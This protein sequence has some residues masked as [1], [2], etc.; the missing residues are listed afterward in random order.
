MGKDYWAEEM[1]AS[2]KD[3]DYWAEEMGGGEKTPKTNIAVGV[4]KGMLDVVRGAT[5]PLVETSA[6]TLQGIEGLAKQ[7]MG[8]EPTMRTYNVP[9]YGEI[10][11][12]QN[13]K[14]AAGNALQTSATILPT[15]KPALAGAM[16]SGG[17]SLSRNED[18]ISTAFNT[19]LGAIT[20][21]VSSSVMGLDKAKLIQQAGNIYRKVLRPTASEIKKIDIGKGGDINTYFQLAAKEKL[22]I[23]MTEGKLNTTEAISALQAKQSNLHEQLNN[24]LSKDT[25]KRFNLNNIRQ[26]AKLNAS[27]SIKNASELKV[28]KNNIDSL[29]DA[30]IERLGGEKI[31][32]AQ[33]L[34]NI[35]QGMWSVSYNP[36]D[37][38]QNVKADS[39]RKIGYI[40]KTMIEDFAPSSAIQ[41]LN[42]LSGDYATLQ[43]LLEN[44]H[45]RSA[46]T[47]IKEGLGRLIGGVAGA[48]T[49]HPII[50]TITGQ[51]VGGRVVGL[52]NNPDIAT[53]FAQWKMSRGVK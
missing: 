8:R 14:Q 22:P 28:V 32:N 17:G 50:G 2:P 26:K 35:K 40:A 18:A 9:F 10:P 41:K 29:I 3:K 46:G 6:H 16:F 20:G 31:V 53:K 38:A 12:I 47:L 37:A 13:I 21:K 34:N 52:L 30:E 44:A 25:A 23:K 11:P 19:T 7:A 24:Q 51:E 33:Q 36:L 45:G 42:K 15:L 5:R 48:A 4:G 1:V 27:A 39:A 43:R 49:P